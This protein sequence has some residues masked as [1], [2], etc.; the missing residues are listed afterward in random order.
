M[1]GFVKTPTILQMEAA[2]C[3][4]A[5]LA[6]LIMYH[7]GHVPMEKIRVDAGVSRDGSKAGNLIRAAKKYGMEGHGYKRPF[8]ALVQMQPP[9]IILLNYGHFVVFEG[10]KK[11]DAYLNDPAVGRR[12]LTIKELDAIYGGVVLTFT[13]T[14]EFKKEKSNSSLKDLFRRAERYRKDYLAALVAGLLTAGVCAAIVKLIERFITLRTLPNTADSAGRPMWIGELICVLLIV[15]EILLLWRQSAIRARLRYRVALPSARRFVTKLLRLPLS[16][17]EQRYPGELVQRTQK[18]NATDHFVTGRLPDVIFGLAA[19]A[20]FFIMMCVYQPILGLIAAGF[21]VLQL[22]VMA[23]LSQKADSVSIGL[24]AEENRLA[25][26][27]YAG[28][29]I[30]GTLKASGAERDYPE[31]IEQQQAMINRA[32]HRL[33][34]TRQLTGAAASLLRYILLV[35]LIVLGGYM[36]ALGKMTP[37]KYVAFMVLFVAFFAPIDTIVPMITRLGVIKADMESAN[38]VLQYE[39]DEIYHADSFGKTKK[40]EGEI[41]LKHIDFA[42]S[43][44]DKPL[45]DD[46]SLKI[47]PGT[48]VAI[49]GATGSG[50]STIAKLISGLY[51]PRK[52]EIRLDGTDLTRIP[53]S[54]VNASIATVS[55]NITLFSGTVRDNISMWNSK[56]ADADIANAAKDACLSDFIRSKPDG[57]DTMI[58]ENGANLSGGQRQRIEIARA[59]AVNPTILIMDEATSALDPIT[60]DRIIKNIRR[61][62]CTCVMIAHRL[63][64]VRDSDTIVVMEHGKIAQRG[65][66]EKLAAMDGPYRELIR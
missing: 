42:Y 25:G 16:F 38:D 61:R 44:L 34:R 35:I 31:K 13:P 9:C 53:K 49:V 4:A 12:R 59:L 48:M 65:T 19:S 32:E 33:I 37:G 22:F 30:I 2:E 66:H 27:L 39:D 43:S 45:I 11:N 24:S 5:S 63:S 29:R 1:K 51:R 57:F 18:N 3:G 52:G 40:L 58:K 26:K 41:I 8:A 50:K 14:G 64:A 10:T 62:G 56:I 28:L 7:G 23:M 46:L 20:V 21:F 6:M 54:V 36:T 17:Y 47:D 15:L 55:Q 60:E